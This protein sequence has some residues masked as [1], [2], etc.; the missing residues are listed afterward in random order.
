MLS[1]PPSRFLSGD[2][3][4]TIVVLRWF[5]IFLRLMSSSLRCMMGSPTLADYSVCGLKKG[6]SA[7]RARKKSSSPASPTYSK[8]TAKLGC[9]FGRILET[10][11]LLP[12]EHSVS[13]AS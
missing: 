7:S 5:E 2:K 1:Q 3:K 10:L 9:R 12:Q 11:L 8:D 13:P 4:A 6:F